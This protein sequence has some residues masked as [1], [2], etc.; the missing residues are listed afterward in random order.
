MVSSFW[1]IH[2]S[3][4]TSI[5]TASVIIV[6]VTLA[7]LVTRQVLSAD[8]ISEKI[9]FVLIIIIG[10]GVGP[11]IFFR[12][13]SHMSKEARSKSYFLTII[14]R[15]TWIIQ[16]SL[17][18]LFLFILFY[19]ETRIV[20]SAIFA[21]SSVMASIIMGLIAFK[22]FSWY[23]QSHNKSIIVL[24]Y[25]IA[26]IML[27]ISIVE[28][29]GT[30]LLM[31]Q[32]VQ[33][34]LPSGTTTGDSSFSYKPSEKYNAEIV[35]KEI[36][37]DTVTFLILPNSIL[38][39]Y[40]LLNSTVLPI[41]FV[42]RWIASTMLL[43]SSYHGNGK[44]PHSLWIVLS[45]P[46]ILYLVGKIPGFFSGES[47]E[48]VDEAYRYYFRIL[49]RAGTI[50]GNILFGLA[51]FMVAR[52]MPSSNL[53]DFLI[54]TGIGNTIVGIALSTSA[55]EPTYGLAAHSLVLLSS[56]LFSVGLYLSAISALHNISLRELIRK[57]AIELLNTIGT[58][59][60]EQKIK[61]KVLRITKERS[62]S[63]KIRTGV[64]PS[65]TEHE[66]KQFTDTIL[67][68]IKVLQAPH[69]IMEKE[70][71]ILQDS[72]EYLT[73]SSF[74]QLQLAYDNYFD[75]YRKVM[76][77]VK[78]RKH[79]GVRMVTYIN[80]EAIPLAKDYH[81]IG[82]QI[83]HVENLPPFDFSL[84]DKEIASLTIEKIDKEKTIHNL[85]VSNEL[86][87]VK[88]FRSIF[89]EFWI[90]GVDLFP[91]I[92]EI[93]EGPEPEFFELVSDPM[94]AAQILLDLTKSA[95]KEILFLLPNDKAVIRMEKLGV[96][97]NLL[98]ISLNGA[99]VKII[100]PQTQINSDIIESL[101]NNSSNI[102]ITHGNDCTTGMLISD[103]A[104]FFQAELRDP[105]AEEFSNA[106]GFAFYSNS[107]LS[108]KS[109]RL[110]FELLWNERSL[111]EELKKA[112]EMQKQ[113]INIAAHELRTPIQPILSS[114]TLLIRKATDDNQRQFLEIINRNAR[115]LLRLTEEILDIARIE[116]NT[117]KLNKETLSLNEIIYNIIGDYKSRIEKK[118]GKLNL[119]YE[120]KE[121]ILIQADRTRL[122]Q[123]ISNLIDNAMKFTEEGSI[124]ITTELIN[125]YVIV[126][127]KDTGI[128]IDPEIFPKLFSKFTSKSDMGTGLGLFICKNIIEAHGGRI[129][130]DDNKE[131]SI[132]KCIGNKGASFYFTLPTVKA[133]DQ[134]I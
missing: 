1:H 91:R 8:D 11:W 20:T 59:E 117:L 103:N 94:K 113:F 81:N 26:A 122:S 34:K 14:H 95:K 118:N 79:I 109:F 17:L 111:N 35:R 127:I 49:F 12:Y 102:K 21:I 126:R 13:S 19:G 31:V 45:L 6:L 104:K 123:V 110:F 7:L 47:L 131:S 25:G 42:F 5:I 116:G 85:L 119:V 101:L 10:Y 64:S 15:V 56:Y 51:F 88:Y 78:K 36:K 18:G 82:I 129:W 32:V 114:S 44:L 108:I 23:R 89:E 84:S 60:I 27:A 69:E 86:V 77:K 107:K 40:N 53:R 70:K 29:A 93:E 37:Q 125:D 87:Y 57:S 120:N 50:A 112:D 71:K 22:F 52:R 9:L 24:F 76:D 75:L 61:T 68:E 83:R 48:G 97:D 124:C 16:F 121:D 130:A 66:I 63:M 90:K 4:K 41:A 65:L 58:A 67:Q 55:L 98:K 133:K 72:S 92:K 74:N 43:R 80:K 100:C 33:E 99:V 3:N 54:I 73:C 30:K 132:D 106:I 38:A 105:L 134:T 46:L 115:K 2:P 28:D 39:Y 62:E 96:I 128:G